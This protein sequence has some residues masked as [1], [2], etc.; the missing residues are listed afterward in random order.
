MPTSSPGRIASPC[1]KPGYGAKRVQMTV[2]PRRAYPVSPALRRVA[3]LRL[4]EVGLRSG[5]RAE[6]RVHSV[7]AYKLDLWRYG[8][9]KERW[10]PRSAGSTSTA[11]GPRCRSR[12]TA[13]TPRRASSGTRRLRQSGSTRS[14]STAPERSGLYYFHARTAS[15]RFFRSPGSWPRRGP[16]RTI[17]VLASNITWNA[18]NNFGGRSNYI[19]ADELPPTPT[20]NARLELTRYTDPE[21]GTW[22]ATP[23]PRCRSTGPSR[24]TTCPRTSR[25]PTRSRAA[26]R[27][28]WRRPS[29]GCWAG[30]S[31]KDFAYDFYAETQLH[32]GLLDLDAYRV[33]ILGTHPEYWS[34][35]DVRP[36][37][38]VGLRARRPA[39]VPG[40]QRPELRGRFARRRDD[41]RP[42]RRR[43]RASTRRA[44]VP[45]AGSP[46]RTNRRPTCWA[47]SSPRPAS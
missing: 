32:D 22:N 12:P 8:W 11:R 43:S 5:E 6:F 46:S 14:T 30:S 40:R 36:R 10:R 1:S 3:R 18:Y 26:P 39:D 41:G 9:H 19:H 23:T 2:T 16:R 35:R 4:A 28:T 7:E 44:T 13:T 33:L 31:A 42:Q 47:W 17:A 15:G 37:Q 38:A 25:S 45:R 29:G 21:F 34:R 20:V 24:S 27:A